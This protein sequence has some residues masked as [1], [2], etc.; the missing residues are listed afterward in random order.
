VR[1]YYNSSIIFI[2][3]PTQP[4]FP[5]FRDQAINLGKHSLMIMFREVADGIHEWLATHID[6]M[7]RTIHDIAQ[8]GMRMW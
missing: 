3:A 2:V 6:G 5:A 1:D 4:P 7:G 8:N